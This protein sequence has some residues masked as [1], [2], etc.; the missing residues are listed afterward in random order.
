MNDR[1]GPHAPRHQSGH[2]VASPSI[3]PDLIEAL[4]R[5][6]RRWSVAVRTGAKT[7]QSHVRANVDEWVDMLDELDTAWNAI[8]HR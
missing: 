7:L 4:R 5:H 6:P 2:R 8:V 1:P 3:S